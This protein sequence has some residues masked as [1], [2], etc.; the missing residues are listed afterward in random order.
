MLLE[1]TTLVMSNWRLSMRRRKAG[2]EAH[3]RRDKEF[4]VGERAREGGHHRGFVGVVAV[5]VGDFDLQGDV[6]L[7]AQLDHGDVILPLTA[8]INITNKA[9]VHGFSQ[10]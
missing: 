7:V 2:N 1:S 6:F 3:I 9:C 4:R 10:K 5:Q 8:T